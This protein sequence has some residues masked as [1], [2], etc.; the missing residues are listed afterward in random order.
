MSN[1][2]NFALNNISEA[3][4]TLLKLQR[5]DFLNHLQVIQGFLQ[6]GTTDRALRYMEDI[7]EDVR[8]IEKLLAKAKDL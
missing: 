4:K 5:H 8:D 7:I 6:L 2:D 1:G 3:C